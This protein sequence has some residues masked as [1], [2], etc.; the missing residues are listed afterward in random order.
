MTLH[1][2]NAYSSPE[3]I[4]PS[5]FPANERF[6]YFFCQNYNCWGCD[7][8]TQ[9]CKTGEHKASLAFWPGFSFSPCSQHGPW[10]PVHSEDTQTRAESQRFP[11]YWLPN[12]TSHRELSPCSQIH[13]Y[14]QLVSSGPKAPP[15][16]ARRRRSL[17]RPRALPTQPFKFQMQVPGCQKAV[18]YGLFP[19]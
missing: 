1:Q 14:H 9:F 4:Q 19:P 15:L 8:Q 6:Y 13:I 5:K 16:P 10:V 7:H 17:Q 11:G 3:S 18:L 12:G 2:S